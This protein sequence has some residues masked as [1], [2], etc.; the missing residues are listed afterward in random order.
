MMTGTIQ[1]WRSED[2]WA[3]LEPFC[4]AHRT[5][6]RIL[7]MG[8]GGSEG[9]SQPPWITGH[10]G[11]RLNLGFALGRLL[12]EP[13]GGWSLKPYW[14]KP[15][16]RNFREGGWKHDHGSRT[17]AQRESVGIA[18]VPYRACASALPDRAPVGTDP[19]ADPGVVSEDRAVA[20]LPPT[21][22]AYNTNA[23]NPSTTKPTLT[24]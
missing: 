22:L 18:T 10:A 23:Q 6:R 5:L 2:L 3:Q 1:P 8:R 14:G 12:A 21:S 15:T 20:W 11:I 16:V 4:P 7:R 19:S 17:E 13:R 24:P 9:R